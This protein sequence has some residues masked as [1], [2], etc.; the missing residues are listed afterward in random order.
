MR[1]TAPDEDRTNRVREE[2]QF[3]LER[4][5]LLALREYVPG[6]QLLAGGRLIRSRGI[7]KHWTGENIDT[8]IGLRGQY[9]K[10]KNGHLYY[11]TS[12][13]TIPDCPFCREPAGQSPVPYLVPQYGFS[14][15]AWDPPKWSTDQELVGSVETVSATF[16]PAALEGSGYTRQE[17]FGGVE[18]LT[19]FYREDGELLIYNRGDKEC[20]FA[21][22]LS[23]GYSDS[24]IKYGEGRVGLPSDFGS[25]APLNSPRYTR[26]CWRAN[27]VPPVLRNQ[28]LAARE[29]TDVLLLDFS[30]CLGDQQADLALVTT[31]GYGL[32]RAAA[33]ML[34]L[35]GRE[36]GV[37]TTPAGV[38]GQGWG[39]LLYDNVP[40]GAGHVRELLEYGEELLELTKEVL[41]VGA[42]H[43]QRCRSACLDCLLSFETQDAMHQGNLNRPLALSVLSNLLDGK[44]PGAHSTPNTDNHADDEVE[45]PPAEPGLTIEERQNRAR[46]NRAKSGRT[47]R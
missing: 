7:L 16:T 43:D 31:L 22:C 47:R 5:G 27:V 45:D 37:D 21:I 12:G 8:A 44:E 9:T 4:N 11:W 32:H 36:I 19:A 24:E 33:K 42:A 34:Q 1:V 20:G 15:A 41:F 14:S 35:D 29:V 2:D 26:R 28:T 25:H 13:A 18:G 17:D 30:Q 3:R 46:A 10:C 39:A 23:C 40:G 6:S 38:S